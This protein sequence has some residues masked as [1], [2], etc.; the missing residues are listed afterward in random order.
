MQMDNTKGV[1]NAWTEVMLQ[2]CDSTHATNGRI[3]KQHKSLL[4]PHS[5]V[6]NNMVSLIQ[7]NLKTSFI[8]IRKCFWLQKKMMSHR[9]NKKTV[10]GRQWTAFNLPYATQKL[11]SIPPGFNMASP[12]PT[13]LQTFNAHAQDYPVLQIFNSPIFF[14]RSMDNDEDTG[15]NTDKVS[16]TKQN[17][18]CPT[19]KCSSTHI[20]MR[21]NLSEWTQVLQ[22]RDFFKTKT[23]HSQKTKGKIKKSDLHT[24]VPC[25][26]IKYKLKTIK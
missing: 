25:A 3:V 6:I 11:R 13:G 14:L 7:T 2:E 20:V 4:N 24:R 22:L 26:F 10:W 18:M 1:N 21:D 17:L 19:A 15:H 8:W 12:L 16:A 5:A 9:I 23:F